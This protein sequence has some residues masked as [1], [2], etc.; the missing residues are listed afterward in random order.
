MASNSIFAA[1]AVE[2]SDAQLRQKIV[3][4]WFS[5]ELPNL[6]EHIGTRLQYY[7]DGQVIGDYRISGPGSESYLRTLGR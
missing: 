6:M 3:G 2:L 4:V 5:E 7:P 1:P